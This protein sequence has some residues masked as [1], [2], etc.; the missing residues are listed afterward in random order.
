MTYP[1]DPGP[2]GWP[3]G[4]QQQPYPQQPPPQYPQQPYPQQQYPQQPYPPTGPQPQYVPPGQPQYGQPTAP[5][6]QPTAPYPDQ[7]GVPYGHPLGPATYWQPPPPPKRRTGLIAGVIVAVLVLAGGGFGTWFALNRTASAAATGAATPMAAAT[8]LMSD[9]GKSDAVGLIDDLPPAEASFLRDSANDSTDQLKRLQVL[10]PDANPANQ[11]TAYIQTQGIRFDPDVQ[12]VN[13]HLAITTLV[14]GT[15][16]INSN[17]A[18]SEYTDKFFK[19][20]FRNGQPTSKTETFTVDQPVRIATVKV[21]GLWYPSLFYSLADAGLRASHESWPTTSIPAVG[22]ASADT[23]VR[24]FVQAL[25]DRDATKAIGMTAPDEMA[26]LHDAGP[27]IVAAVGPG[28]PSGIHIVSMS[29]ADKNVTNGVDAVLA[30]LT[31]DQNGQQIQVSKTG[32][33][34]SVT[35][36]GQTQKM[37][38]SDLSNQMHQ[39]AGDFL[40]PALDKFLSDLSAG[41]MNG[42]VGIVATQVDGQWYVSP[43]RTVTQ[44][45]LSVFNSITADDL[46]G[47]LQLG[48]H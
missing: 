7:T 25:F 44:L 38:A 37:C 40:P 10:K 8:K 45:V 9:V 13:D 36:Q 30:S 1:G 6:G 2:G 17:A 31:L 4:G 22:S 48:S 27:A 12:Q 5:Y 47:L 34:Y 35:V 16:T 21:N 42:G 43:S 33:C 32:G 29:F 41:L 20:M 24:G 26:A 3:Q 23:A 28:S 39:G 11:S 19:A 14:A 46:S 18:S 15:I